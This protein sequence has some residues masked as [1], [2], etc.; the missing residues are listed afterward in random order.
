[1]TDNER[2]NVGQNRRE[3]DSKSAQLDLEIKRAELASKKRD[4]DTPKWS[5]PLVIAIMAGAL[6]AL[7]NAV[8]AVINGGQQVALEDRKSEQSRILKVIETGDTERAAENLRFLLET[9]LI[10]DQRYRDKLTSF[11]STRKTGQGP[12]LASAGINFGAGPE[13]DRILAR[14]R[15]MSCKLKKSH[16]LWV[17]DANP[18][19]NS[20]ERKVLESFGVRFDLTISSEEAMQ[21]VSKVHYD[22]IISDL[23]RDK[24]SINNTPCFANSA[25]PSGAGCAL[26][27]MVHD[28]YGEKAPPLILYS[29]GFPSAAGTPPFV[30]SVTDRVDTLFH[31]IFDVVDRQ[32]CP[33]D[34]AAE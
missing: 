29:A 34:P 25:T 19:Q 3:V 16:I 33:R 18:S 9:G 32:D 1:M 11:L 17:D 10:E 27:K 12:A 15:N 21:R 8:V 2:E 31:L 13:F 22:A 23:N 26:A 14:A 20:T 28:S 6:A 5:N 24:E 7:G 30:F 4:L